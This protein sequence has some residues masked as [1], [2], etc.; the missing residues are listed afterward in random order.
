MNKT[1]LK[2]GI[3]ALVTTAA[4]MAPA[5]YACDHAGGQHPHKAKHGQRMGHH[6]GMHQMFRGLELT[7][8]QKASIKTVME[9]HRESRKENRPSQEERQAYKAQMLEYVTADKFDEAKMKKA[10]QER[11][12]KRNQAA[13]DTVKVHRDIY[14][15]LTPEQQAKFKENFAKQPKHCDNKGKRKGDRS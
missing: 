6:G 12:A 7:D 2:S 10:M 5:A 15:L 9:K 13:I 1:T 4:L 14:K 11:Q 8:E 3:L